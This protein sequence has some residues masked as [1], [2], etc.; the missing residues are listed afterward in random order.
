MRVWR[1]TREGTL[2]SPE[3]GLVVGYL[4]MWLWKKGLP[5]P[6]VED[7]GVGR[8]VSWYA[9]RSWVRFRMFAF[10]PG[11]AMCGG[12]QREGAAMEQAVPFR[13]FSHVR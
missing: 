4:I 7:C 13:R 12:C 8:A 9:M 5:G 11:A 6:R 1:R 2:E 3:R 10:L